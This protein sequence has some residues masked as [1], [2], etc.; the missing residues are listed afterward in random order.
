MLLSKHGRC[1][2]LAWSSLVLGGTEVK[3]RGYLG[4]SDNGLHDT[5]G[6]IDKSVDIEPSGKGQDSG[7]KFARKLAG[8]VVDCLGEII[9]KSS[10]TLLDFKKSVVTKN[11]LHEK[12][13]ELR[14]TDIATVDDRAV[15]LV[16]TVTSGN[17]I[18][19]REQWDKKKRTPDQQNGKNWKN[20]G[21]GELGVINLQT[22]RGEPKSGEGNFKFC[23]HDTTTDALVKVDRF[24]FT[25]FDLDQR[26][27]GIK[28]K[29]LMYA[30]TAQPKLW[31][32]TTSSHISLF[33]ED[34]ESTVP[35]D[36][37]TRTVFH[38]STKGNGPDNPTDPSDLSQK[39]KKR[40]VAFTFI[41]TD[42]FEFTYDH[43]CPSEVNGSSLCSRYTGGN[44]LFGGAA[45]E[46]IEEGECVVTPTLPPK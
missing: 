5:Y 14:Y 32:D 29:L 9:D 45:H 43:Y 7:S 38:S 6:D 2:L 3:A 18:D 30:A 28:E 16:V 17:Y 1:I 37:N 26:K 41:D 19:I 8:S 46:I 22:V 31:P 36:E 39:Q 15:S 11:T 21:K 12:G 20:G 25:I 23:F 44:F 10:V 33:C 27:N 40:S 24:D 13:G 42:C 35:C 34:E 4:G